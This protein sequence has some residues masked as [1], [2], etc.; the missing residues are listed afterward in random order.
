MFSK[1]GLH[2]HL[3][4]TCDFLK[5]GCLFSCLCDNSLPFCLQ[6]WKCGDSFVSQTTIT[7]LLLLSICFGK[8]S[9]FNDIIFSACR[10]LVTCDGLGQ[11]SD[12]FPLP[13][14]FWSSS[15]S[16]I[17]LFIYSFLHSSTYS[18]YNFF[19]RLSEQRKVKQVG[20]LL[21]LCTKIHKYM[22]KISE[23][24]CI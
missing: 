6:Y 18:I 14:T 21:S 23:G 5:H 4:I 9:V 20:W 1:V 16:S 13:C 2:C 8:Q 12:S 24:L 22:K 15:L 10:T 17:H 11:S 7:V 3:G 19:M